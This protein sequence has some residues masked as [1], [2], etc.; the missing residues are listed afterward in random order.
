[1]LRRL[2]ELHTGA[3]E[4]DPFPQLADLAVHDASFDDHGAVAERQPEVVEGTELQGELRLDLR[5]AVAQVEDRHRLV[6][7]DFSGHHPG[8]VDALGIAL[9]ACHRITYRTLTRI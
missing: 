7:R 2:D 1:M 9:F 4:D 8:D 5:A 3:I 6:D